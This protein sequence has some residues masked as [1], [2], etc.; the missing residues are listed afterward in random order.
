MKLK[1]PE[2]N[3]IIVFEPEDYLSAIVS[4]LLDDDYYLCCAHNAAE[5]KAILEKEEDRILFLLALDETEQYD[6]MEIIE[7]YRNEPW[8]EGALSFVVAKEHHPG[9]EEKADALGIQDY[10]QLSSVLPADYERVLTSCISRQLRLMKKFQR[11]KKSANCDGLTGLYNHAAAENIVAKMLRSNP[12]QE[13]LFSIIDIDYFKQVNDE[14]GHEF[15]DKVLKEESKRIQQIIGE[16][17]LAIR[18]GG[19]EFLLMAPIFSDVEEIARRIYEKTHFQLEDYQITNSIGITTT[20]SCDREWESLFRQADQAL[21]TAKVNGRNQYCIYTADMSRK[22]DG[23]GEEIRNETLNLSPSAL[24]HA[25]VDNCILACH[26]DLCKVAVTKLC[27]TASGEY[28]WSDPMEYIPF[29]KNLLEL[30][31]EKSQLRFSEFI[32]PNTL[33]GRLKTA[34]TLTYF[35]AGVD[36]KQYRAEYLAG[37]R[38]D[39]GQI[40]NAL[41]LIGEADHLEHGASQD[42]AAAVDKCLASGLMQTYNAIW[43]I[44][45]A[46]FSRELVSIQTDISRHRRINRLIEGGN[47]WEDTQRYLQMYVNEEERKDLLKSLHPDVVFRE[48]GEKGMYTLH[49]HRKVDGITNCCEYSFIS[50]MYGGEKVILQLYRRLQET[51]E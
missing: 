25:L 26:L 4:K 9:R 44:H 22:L 36:G 5:L 49:F 24:I 42:D 6:T 35:F 45:P 48:V 11:L 16:Q 47:Y 50:A 33:A 14:R 12:E 7:A 1:I 27:K 43:M 28:G 38:A 19:D 51:K 13:F 29:I 17:V 10:L 46:T 23:A 8:F 2:G 32:N 3:V 31:E 21:Y 18:Y 37:D 20:L 30:V 39:D 40:T 15:G 34:S 41:L